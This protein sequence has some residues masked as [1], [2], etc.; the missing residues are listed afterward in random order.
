MPYGQ[1][2]KFQSR[3]EDLNVDTKHLGLGPGGKLGWKVGDLN[4]YGAC[5]DATKATEE[6]GKSA[7]DHVAERFVEMLGEVHAYKLDQRI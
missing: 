7:V 5:G 3:I 4:P 2:A 6:T 1:C